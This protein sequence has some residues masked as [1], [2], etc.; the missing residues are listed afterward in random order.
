MKFS[1]LLEKCGKKYTEQGDD[2]KKDREFDVLAD[3]IIE[4]VFVLPTD[5]LIDVFVDLV[6]NDKGGTGTLSE[7]ISY[8]EPTQTIRDYAEEV[9]YNV[10]YGRLT[11]KIR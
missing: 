6:E 3:V 11:D 2:H 7:V 9:V 8:M 1:E 10:I 4:E 5:K